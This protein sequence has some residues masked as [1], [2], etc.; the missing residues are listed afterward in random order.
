MGSTIGSEG[1]GKIV[2][3]Y[4]SSHLEAHKK[5]GKRRYLE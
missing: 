2:R 4:A 3:E 5:M 1:D